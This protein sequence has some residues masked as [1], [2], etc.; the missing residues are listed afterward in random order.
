MAINTDL[1]TGILALSPSF[2]SIYL[3]ITS[4]QHFFNWNK[5]TKKDTKKK[6]QKQII[7]ELFF[8]YCQVSLLYFPRHIYRFS[9]PVDIEYCH[10]TE[11]ISFSQLLSIWM[12]IIYNRM[13]TLV[14]K[15]K[16]RQSYHNNVYTAIYFTCIWLL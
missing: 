2:F 8:F 6:S 11:I 4:L 9:W 10:G 15:E 5:Q 14:I 16:K 7:L 13:K 12:Y 1:Y 3:T